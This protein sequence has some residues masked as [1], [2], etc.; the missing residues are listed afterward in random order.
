MAEGFDEQSQAPL[1]LK[2]YQDLLLRR[3]WFVLVPLFVGWALVWGAS[4]M[5]PSVYRSST[6][7]LVMQPAVSQS[8]VSADPGADLQDRLD[9]IQQ[10]IRS[11]TLLLDIAQRFNLY[12][13]DRRRMN[14]DALV[15]KMN[16]D[17]DIELVRSPGKNE[18][19]S[20]SISFDA[21]T[22]SAAQAVTSELSS[23]VTSEDF[24]EVQRSNENT[25]KF[26]DAQLEDARAKMA[27]Q[28]EKVRIFQDRY[29]GEL[30]T[31]QTSNLQIL[32]GYQAQLQS[33]Q[34]QLGQAMQHK[35]LLESLQ[36]QYKTMGVVG[37]RSGDANPTGLGAIDQELAKE[38]DDLTDLLSKYTEQHPD[39][40]KKKEQ[41]AQTEKLRAQKAEELK[42]KAAEPAHDAAAVDASDPRTAA[43]VEVEAQL[44]AN[45]TE[46]ANR[47]RAIADVQAKINEYQSRLNSA[48]A[49]EQ[50]LDDLTRD[51][52]QS[53]KYY[54]DLLA[55]KNKA[56]MTAN[57]GKSQ[58]GLHFNIQ[59]P[60]SLPSRP[61]APKRFL[62]SL[63]GLAAGLALG[64]VAAMGAE[65]LD[66]R[67][68][69]EGE[70]EELVPVEVIAE[71][72]PLPTPQEESARS[73]RFLLEWAAAGLM[74]A[75]IFM[76][77]AISFLRG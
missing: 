5:M 38:R 17:L 53:K 67:I 3:R 60:P 40:R 15:A 22:P 23:R 64:V 55:Q 14:D 13:K 30:P 56:E 51:D 27:A 6:M 43:L 33:E 63:G 28:D 49:R 57:L 37:G 71:I 9:S 70:F 21:D 47:Q 72:P 65:F 39:V 34:D 54:N 41:I 19:T 75:V 25:V 59:D 62:F 26:L 61:F 58:E 24:Q 7:I 48:P 69:D 35:T 50:E 2:K 31:Q 12:A 73:R 74:S 20:F 10:Q 44:K 66:H 76:G 45:A 8:I 32:G 46:I 52:E 18:L 77:T 42:A 1:D 68:Y 36:N 11:R 16:K 29:M 4:W